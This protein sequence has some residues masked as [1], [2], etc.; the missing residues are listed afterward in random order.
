MTFQHPRRVVITGLGVVAPNGIGGK[1]FW[2]ATSKGI[3]GIKPVQRF[4][5]VN[6]PIQVAGEVCDFQVEHYID[7]KL[8]NRTDRMTHLVFAAVQ[9]ALEDA[10]VALEQEN[11]QRVGVVIAN[12]FGGAEFALNQVE[13]FHMRGPR[14]MSVYTAIACLQ[15]ANVGQVSVRYGL[16]GYCKTP[17]NDAVGGLDAL[18][19]A[20]SAIR[21][22]V[23]DVLITGGCEAL[24]H[25]YFLL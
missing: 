21:R 15:I 13:V 8:V 12:T 7:R 3:S 2:H 9:E 14:Y 22:G 20:Y 5:T 19:I 1:A 6:L 16:Q 24:L 11:L 4:P 17:I 10:R 23:V 25:P 18:G